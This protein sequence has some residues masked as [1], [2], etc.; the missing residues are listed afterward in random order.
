LISV[1]GGKSDCGQQNCLATRTKERFQTRD[2]VRTCN[3][4]F[5]EGTG[6]VLDQHHCIVA[7]LAW[8]G[9]IR[10]GRHQTHDAGSICKNHEQLG[11]QQHSDSERNVPPRRSSQAKAFPRRA[12]SMHQINGDEDDAQADPGQL[13]SVHPVRDGDGRRREEC[14]RVDQVRHDA[15]RR[16]GSNFEPRGPAGHDRRVLF[17]VAL[18]G[19]RF[20]GLQ[21]CHGCGFGRGLRLRGVRPA[22]GGTHIARAHRGPTSEAAESRV[23]RLLRSGVR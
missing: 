20:R 7:G 22:A 9:E 21:R 1:V 19:G 10:I 11:N 12:T 3:Q 14:N 15:D 2:E 17:G 8:S 23:V 6:S 5:R 16:Y 13:Q 18:T 4:F